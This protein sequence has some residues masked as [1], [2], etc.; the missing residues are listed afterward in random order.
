MKKLL[1]LTIALLTLATGQSRELRIMTFN[2]RFGERAD[3][4]QIAEAIRREKPDLVALQEVDINTQRERN[5]AAGS[6]HYI[7]QLAGYTQMH[8]LFGR[9]IHYRGGEYGIAILSAY[10]FERSSNDKYTVQGKED[11]TALSVIVDTGNGKKVRFV[12]THLDAF[13]DN[14]R[15]QQ[16]DELCLRYA[17]PD[18]PTIVAGDFNEAPGGETIK[19]FDTEFTRTCGSQPTFPA[20]NPRVKIDYIAFTP[21]DAFRA[22]KVKVLDTHTLSDHCAVVVKLKPKY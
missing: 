16:V 4:E 12:C 18:I 3:M 11:R 5:V 14:V 8:A 20:D 6:A 9:T 13:D 21:T 7:A 22:G 1:L 19:R 15:R 2:I 17:D 10:S